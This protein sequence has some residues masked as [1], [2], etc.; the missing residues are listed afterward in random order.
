MPGAKAVV[1]MIRGTARIGSGTTETDPEKPDKTV[2][3]L[4]STSVSSLSGDPR[5]AMAD[6]GEQESGGQA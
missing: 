5:K 4:G 1:P 6:S 3:L 2:P